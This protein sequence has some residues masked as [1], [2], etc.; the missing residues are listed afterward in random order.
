[1]SRYDE[2]P[3]LD[4]LEEKTTKKRKK[5]NIFEL[6]YNKEKVEDDPGDRDVERNFKFFFTLMGRNTRRFFS[7]NLLLV[8]CN[9]PIFLLM[10]AFS[11]NLHKTAI[12]PASAIAAPIYGASLFGAASPASSAMY[13]LY[14]V[15]TPFSYWTPA[16]IRPYRPARSGC[17]T[18]LRYSYVPPRIFD[19][20]CSNCSAGQG[21]CQ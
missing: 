20:C 19:S 5:F 21:M 11:Q 2:R 9:F 4:D 16:A 12:A 15:S 14:G 7:L 17:Q 3:R 10:L 18:N 8:F 1:M 6:M 13:G